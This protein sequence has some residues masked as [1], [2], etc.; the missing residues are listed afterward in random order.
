MEQPNRDK[1]LET[2]IWAC[3]TEYGFKAYKLFS[4]REETNVQCCIVMQNNDCSF[5]K[6]LDPLTSTLDPLTDSDE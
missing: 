3:V 1:S 6:C 4:C 5:C 2:E